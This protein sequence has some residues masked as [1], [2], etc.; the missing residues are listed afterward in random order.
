MP[1]NP[2]FPPTGICSKLG[3]HLE[4]KMIPDIVFPFGYF[5]GRLLKVSKSCLAF[6]VARIAPFTKKR[7]PPPVQS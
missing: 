4:P 3:C 5:L 1:L 6:F 7:K 2:N